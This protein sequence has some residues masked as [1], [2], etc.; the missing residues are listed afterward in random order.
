[1][2][3]VG[4]YSSVHSVIQP[5]I[6]K[7]ILD[8]VSHTSSDAYI[9]DCLTPSLL[10][11]SLGFLVTAVCR[12]YNSIV[13]KSLPKI[14]SDIVTLLTEYLRNQSYAFYHD[15][16]SGDVSAKIADL[17]SNIQSLVNAWFNISRKGF[18]IV[19]T[20]LMVGT[21]SIY[22]ILAT[23]GSIRS[24]DQSVYGINY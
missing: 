22:F 7:V 18:I 3:L 16:L 15:P 13:L 14:K 6:L 8:R 12:L 2:F 5:Y 23:V 9:S 11:I 10:L 21:V 19:L 24:Y 17:T 1:M 20:I 4:V